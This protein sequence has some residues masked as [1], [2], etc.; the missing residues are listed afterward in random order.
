LLILLYFCDTRQRK[1]ALW[2]GSAFPNG[3][4]GRQ[5]RRGYY[6]LSG[7]L[8]MHGESEH[9]KIAISNLFK[10]GFGDNVRQDLLF[11][12]NLGLRTGVSSSQP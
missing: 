2:A 11:L 10:A 7:M 4:M 1:P 5:K 9:L 6:L 8:K 12:N 3:L